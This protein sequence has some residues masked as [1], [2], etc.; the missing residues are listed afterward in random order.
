MTLDLS[1]LDLG[2]LSHED[3]KYP[4]MVTGRTV[5]IDGDFLAYQVSAERPDE[6][7]STE[8]MKHNA[9]VAVEDIRRMA[10]AEHVA[11]HLTP[12]TSNKGHRYD[13]AIQRV[14]QG[15]RQSKEKPR[16]LHAMRTWL[17]DNFNGFLWEQCEADDGMAAA[18]Y[19]AIREGKRELSIVASKDKDLDMVPGLHMV[20][21]T[22]DIVDTAATNND[23][24]GW[25]DLKES[26]SASGM[27]KTKIKGY[28][29]KW[30]WTQML[31]GDTAD[32]IQG[33]P[34]VTGSVLNWIDPTAAVR[35]AYQVVATG[36]DNKKAI[37]AAD[38]ILKSR[39]PKACGPALAIKLLDQMINN[40]I[41]FTAVKGLYEAYGNE[42][43]FKDHAGNNV[44]WQ[45][46]F[47]SEAQLLWMRRDVNDDNDVIHW[48]KEIT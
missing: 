12:F 33:L 44:P 1:I 23:D 30:F 19:T 39:K 3:K 24:F 10:A 27:K 37:A 20:W 9:R 29:H 42:V 11:M 18:Q 46:V 5:Q 7:K 38:K 31:I 28:G 26:R 22:G 45:S 17:S 36:G 35:Q 21:D 25:V 48:F 8:D 6:P 15:N 4:E 13:Q 41:A 40:R 32:N 2:S 16:M 47:V 14:Y 43:G 34:K